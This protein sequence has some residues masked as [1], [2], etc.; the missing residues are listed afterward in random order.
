ML[1]AALAFYALLWIPALLGLIVGL[2]SAWRYSWV[3]ATVGLLFGAAWLSIGNGNIDHVDLRSW[4]DWLLVVA[5]WVAGSFYAG[6]AAGA[7]LRLL[8]SGHA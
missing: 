1:D 4:D 8:D 7:V 2:T 3:G 5:L 6:V